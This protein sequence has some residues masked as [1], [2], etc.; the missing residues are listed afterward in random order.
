MRTVD[1]IMAAACCSIMSNIGSDLMQHIAVLERAELGSTPLQPY[2][3]TRIS[4]AGLAAPI[5]T[6]PEIPERR[7]LK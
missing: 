6:Y 5:G 7:L 4:L 2:F 1:N 3:T